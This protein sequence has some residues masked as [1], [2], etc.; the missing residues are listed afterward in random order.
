MMNV[1]GILQNVPELK[2]IRLDM[3]LFEAKYPVIFTC[4]KENQKYLFSCCAYNTNEVKWIG[5]KTDSNTVLKMLKN[6]MTVR[7]AFLKGDGEMM[8]ISYDGQKVI[9]ECLDKDRVS[10]KLLPAEKMYF[11]AEEGEFQEEMERLRDEIQ[12]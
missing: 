1:E 12:I 8:V 2:G 7:D 11:E 10:P 9:C 6:E 3:V 5:A 4:K